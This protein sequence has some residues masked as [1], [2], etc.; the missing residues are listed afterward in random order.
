MDGGLTGKRK[1]TVVE[2]VDYLGGFIE[3]DVLFPPIFPRKTEVLKAWVK[4]LPEDRVI[5]VM[6]NRDWK[7]TGIELKTAGGRKIF[8]VF[9]RGRIM[10]FDITETPKR[11]KTAIEELLLKFV[12]DT[13]KNALFMKKYRAKVPGHYDDEIEVYLNRYTYEILKG[14]WEIET[15]KKAYLRKT[16]VEDARI[17]PVLD[18]ER[19]F[20]F[21]EVEK[22]EHEDTKIARYYID[23][24][25]IYTKNR[26]HAYIFPI[27]SRN[28]FLNWHWWER[29]DI[30]LFFM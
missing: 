11:H 8:Y 9:D 5:S 2:M 19:F 24:V 20:S 3:L 10:A 6:H 12:P 1:G 18:E 22:M 16:N 26:R 21:S 25:V 23:S 28:A 4:E 27:A 17:L 7:R 15:V 13:G 29:P 30:G 14:V